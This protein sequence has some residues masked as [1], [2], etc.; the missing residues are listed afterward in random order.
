MAACIAN[1]LLEQ[2]VRVLMTNFATIING[3]FSTTDKNDY[4]NAICGYDLLIIDD[5]GVES[6]S[7]YRMEGWINLERF[8]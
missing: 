5:L 7:E 3:I 8:L 6:H 1:A 2:E 4:V